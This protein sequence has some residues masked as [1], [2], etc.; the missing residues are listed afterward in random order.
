MATD[1][2]Q[3]IGGL[4]TIRVDGTQYEARGNFRVTGM[5]VKRTGVAGQDYVHG[6]IEEPIVPQI[7]GEWSIGNQLSIVDLE[8]LTNSTAQVALANGN[9]YV[10][11]NCWATSAFEIDAHDGRVEVTLE[12]LTME[13]IVGGA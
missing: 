8:N 4:M 11:A 1:N 5:T 3:R 2:T 9:T 7:K 10:L 12:G 6:Y 13:E